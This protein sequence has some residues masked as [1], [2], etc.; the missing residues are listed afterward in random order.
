MHTRPALPLPLRLLLALLLVAAATALFDAAREWLTISTV[1]LL[2]LLPVG[3]ASALWGLGPGLT[4]AIASFFVFNFLFIHPYYT[5]NVLRPEDILALL[6]FLVVALVI[7]QLLGR[8]KASLVEALDREREATRLHELST[9]LA[10]AKNV[11]KVAGILAAQAFGTFDADHCRVWVDPGDTDRRFEAVMPES[12]VPPLR[13][14]DAAHPIQGLQSL[15]GEVAVWR[16]SRPLLTSEQRLLKA[17]A[18]ESALAI[19]RGRLAEAENRARV[20]AQSDALKSALLSSVSHELRTPLATI[21]ASVTSLRAGTVEWD[22]D[23]RRDLLLAI[24]EETD[25]LNQLVGNILDMSRIEAGALRPQRS[26]NMLGEVVQSVVRRMR[27]A[28]QYHSVVVEVPE[29][30]PLVPLD[31]V[32]IE[33]VFTNLIANSVKYA[34]AGSVIRIRAQALDDEW[35]LAE[36]TNQG[37]PIPPELLERVFEKFARL[38]GDD[39]VTGSGLGL[40]ICRGIILAHGGRIWAENLAGGVAF[41]FT[42]PLTLPGFP[43]ADGGRP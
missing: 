11:Q 29:D 3:L 15:L 14:P 20:L 5:L 32:Q 23:A 17:Y 16:S 41:R 40:S 30:L 18:S 12:V 31:F 35:L 2:F 34:P 13:K 25:H 36:V 27:S 42:L 38:P 21:K 7:S 33:Q 28:T 6:V 39:R 9:A 22:S 37:P 1:A 19:E 24:E 10:V 43:R 4:A 8:A 26:W